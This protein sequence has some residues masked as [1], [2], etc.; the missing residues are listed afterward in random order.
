MGRNQKEKNW[1]DKT[2]QP[3]CPMCGRFAYWDK[4][5]GRWRLHC[6]MW[7]DYSGGYEHE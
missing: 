3:R 4:L 7:D 1:Y 5:L 6:V 2:K